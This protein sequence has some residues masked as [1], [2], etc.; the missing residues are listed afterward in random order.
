MTEENY[1]RGLPNNIKN[2]L[3]DAELI[4]DANHSAIEEF[5]GDTP[6]DIRG[7]IL[8]YKA[9]FEV[10]TDSEIKEY[11]ELLEK[12]KNKN[13][14]IKKPKNSDDTENK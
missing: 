14:N 9:F 1:I 13:I 10:L 12:Q 5:P 6:D 4:V 7:R 2:E 3:D 11:D 8:A